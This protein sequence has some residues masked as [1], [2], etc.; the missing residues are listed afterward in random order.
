MAD[1]KKS[2]VVHKTYFN[3]KVNEINKLNDKY[4]ELRQKLL[5]GESLPQVE[6]TSTKKPGS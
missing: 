6:K 2:H 4:L 1:S 3:S 5:L